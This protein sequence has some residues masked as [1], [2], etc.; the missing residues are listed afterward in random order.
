M[1][2]C[3]HICFVHY[4]ENTACFG[5]CADQD[6]R[7]GFCVIGYVQYFIGDIAKRFSDNLRKIPAVV[8]EKAGFGALGVP[9]DALLND[10]LLPRKMD[11]LKNLLKD[12][13]WFH[14]LSDEQQHAVAHHLEKI[15]E[16]I[17]R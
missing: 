14:S 7:G 15:I 4:K 12:I 16:V 5:V 10:D 17:R 6:L 2:K 9:L 11:L 8:C 3:E 13:T 1:K